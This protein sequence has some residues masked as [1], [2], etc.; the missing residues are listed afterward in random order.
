MQNVF[1]N[2]AISHGYKQLADRDNWTSQLRIFPT[3]SAIVAIMLEA[4]MQQKTLSSSATQ[5]T[6]QVELLF[7]ALPNMNYGCFNSSP[8]QIVC[9]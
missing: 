1:W 4:W 2:P 5:H 8:S 3:V 9:A 6:M 7:L